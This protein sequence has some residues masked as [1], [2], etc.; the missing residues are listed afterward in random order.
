MQQLIT[1]LFTPPNDGTTVEVFHFYVQWTI[2]NGL[3]ILAWLYYW[4]E[5]RKRFV[6]RHWLH[7]SLLDRATNQFVV[8]GL[9][10]FIIEFF[11]WAADSSL[12]A[13]RFWRY[14][15]LAWVLGLLIYW[16]VYF[17]RRYPGEIAWYREQRIKHRYMNP[18]RNKSKRAKSAAGAR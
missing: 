4:L 7:R 3:L 9:V 13:D 18:P 1:K 8:V 10:G 5:G 12:L 15:W 11:R 16:A 17:I 14:G 6:S 2:F